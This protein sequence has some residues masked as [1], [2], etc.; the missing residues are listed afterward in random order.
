MTEAI[1]EFWR[2]R[3]LA[4][5]IDNNDIMHKLSRFDINDFLLGNNYFENK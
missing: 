5:R 2:K 1:C 4:M 3:W